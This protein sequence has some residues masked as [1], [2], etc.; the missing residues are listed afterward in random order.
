MLELKIV[1]GMSG[2]GKSQFLRMLEDLGFYT[3]DHLPLDLLSDFIRTMRAENR[4]T[5]K[6]AVVVDVRERNHFDVFFHHLESLSPEKSDRSHV[7]L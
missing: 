7:V 6:A 5:V 2:A 1:T 3:V 4:Q